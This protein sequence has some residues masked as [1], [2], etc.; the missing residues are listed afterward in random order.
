MTHQN[1]HRSAPESRKRTGC[2]RSSVCFLALSI[3]SYLLLIAVS[4]QVSGNVLGQPQQPAQLEVLKTTG[5]QDGAVA[6]N[7]VRPLEQGPPVKRE[8]SDGQRHSYRLRLGADQFL[9]ATIEQQ[10]IDVVVK[11][12]GPDGKQILEIDS[13]RRAQGKEEAS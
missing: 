2:Y 13:E 1:K 11:I 3:I 5:P 10:G 8:L 4:P 9:K 12:S 6:E 7:D